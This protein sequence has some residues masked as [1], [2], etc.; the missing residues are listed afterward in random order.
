MSHSSLGQWKKLIKW[1]YL[2]KVCDYIPIIKLFDEV[3]ALLHAYYPC[4]AYTVIHMPMYVE[5][6][7]INS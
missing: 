3:T 2:C 5:T 1:I 6:V 4:T 7:Q